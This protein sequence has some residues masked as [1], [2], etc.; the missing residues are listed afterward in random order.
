MSPP[1]RG[2]EHVD[3]CISGLIDGTIDV[4]CTDHAPHALEKK[5]QELD[6]APF[7]IVG[8]ETC[9]GLVV[10]RLIAPGHLD[11]PTALAKLTI[12]PARILG[13]D[14]G[15]LKVGADADITI[16]D[17][18]IRWIVEPTSFRSK[19]ANTPFGGWELQG[20]AETVIVGGRIKHQSATAP[21]P[22]LL[23]EPERALAGS[24]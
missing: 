7:G 20:Q 16:I 24:R 2:Q 4:I 3:S 1:L 5:M 21:R 8:L 6:Q 17:P 19:S 15:T 18:D 23:G 13:I 14:K 10:T 9:L 22:E 11:W 12:N